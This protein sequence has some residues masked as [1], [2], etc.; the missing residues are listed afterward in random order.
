MKFAP[1]SPEDWTQAANH[2]LRHIA[3][4]NKRWLIYVDE[5]PIFLYTLIKNDPAQGVA[6]VRR[7]LDWFRNDVRAQPQ[8]KDIRWLLTGSVGL[9][10]LAQRHGMADTINSLS[11]QALK[12]FSEAEAA[13]MLSKLT[14]RYR[15]PLTAAHIL[16][17]VQAVGWP[18][19]YYLQRLFEALRR[20]R[21][22]HAASSIEQQI[23]AAIDLLVLP[24]EDNDFHHWEQRLQTQLGDLDAALAQ[25]LL[26]LAAATTDGA[27]AESLFEALQA[28]MV[29]ASEDQ[30]R[31]KF[32][33]LR[34]ILIRD[35]YWYPRGDAT[36]RRY[37][38]HL[39]PLRR[40]WGRRKAL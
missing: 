3:S 5:L 22:E 35:G 19:P 31:R 16:S 8:V 14:A 25:T 18:Q 26:T 4:A 6:R 30:H 12:P 40:W 32:V 23:E 24:G 9:D 17:L 36:A 20:V 21:A 29:D 13:E 39:E 11:H 34:D 15:L 27:R 7:F 33:E 37:A 1:L 10:S 2:A 28:R 38:F